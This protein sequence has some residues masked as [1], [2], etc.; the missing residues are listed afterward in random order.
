MG[1]RLSACDDD[2]N[3]MQRLFILCTTLQTLIAT[4]ASLHVRRWISQQQQQQHR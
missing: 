3:D 1:M 2:F 4:I